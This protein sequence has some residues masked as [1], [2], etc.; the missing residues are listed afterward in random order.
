MIDHLLE[1]L[2][3]AFKRSWVGN[4]DDGPEKRSTNI[5]VFMLQTDPYNSKNANFTNFHKVINY[6][7]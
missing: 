1:Y 6:V 3:N 7:R 5:Q 4:K 2:R